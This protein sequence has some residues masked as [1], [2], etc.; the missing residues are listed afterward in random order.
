MS[1]YRRTFLPPSETFVR[2]HLLN[3][4]RYTPRAVT[5]Y[6]TE[7]PLNV[8]GVAVDVATDRSPLARVRRRLP[9]PL[10]VDQLLDE[11]NGL[12]RLLRAGAPDVLHAHFGTDGAL[13]EKACR[14]AGIPSVVTFHG[15]DATVRPE[16]LAGNAIGRL[17][18]DRWQE[19]VAGPGHVIAVSRYIADQI[20]ARGGSSRRL[21]VVPCGVDTRTFTPTATS[22]DAPMLFVGRL[23]EKKGCADLLR[24]LADHPDLPPL[25][26]VGDGPLRSQLEASAA[27][28]GVHVRFLGVR[29]SAEVRDLMAACSVVVMPSQRASQGDTE[30]L[31]VT[32]LEAAA[33]GRPVVGYA[34]S[35]LVDSVVEGRTGR[36]VPERDVVSLG[37]AL[38]G[39]LA[40]PRQLAEFGAAAR[41][42]VVSNF[43]IRDTTAR[44]EQVY[45]SARRGE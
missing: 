43:D 12:V 37:E 26:V 25:N 33:S 9:G 36:L 23:V 34:H 10:R 35:G 8:P 31:P 16:A 17:L 19:L 44:I 14:R 29:S 40:S 15:Y 4:W 5:T 22:T 6:L 41:E 28:L 7:D 18:L 42:H 27:E 1:V 24:V 13:A 32:S 11:E 38:T 45:D 2:D 20:L 39:L 3:L 30:G 21:H